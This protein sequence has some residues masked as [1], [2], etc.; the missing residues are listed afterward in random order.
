[1]LTPVIIDLIIDILTQKH[2]PA[3]LAQ[4]NPEH[5]AMTDA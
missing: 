1:M 3:R 5:S 2:S 4:L